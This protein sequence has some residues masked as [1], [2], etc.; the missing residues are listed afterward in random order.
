MQDTNKELGVEIRRIRLEQGMT[1]EEL[2][3]I[4]DKSRGNV[5]NLENGR[6]NSSVK[7]LEKVAHAL[8]RKLIISFAKP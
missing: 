8:G 3:D 5:S 1:Q 6:F 4:V 7:Q 2:G